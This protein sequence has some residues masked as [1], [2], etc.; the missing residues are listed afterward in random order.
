M[1][2]NTLTLSQ[3]KHKLDSSRARLFTAPTSSDVYLRPEVS[4]LD[5][6]INDGGNVS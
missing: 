1:R 3:L 6:I 2:H 5:S 4:E